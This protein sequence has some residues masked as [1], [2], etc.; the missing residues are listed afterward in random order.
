MT[1]S[2]QQET[3]SATADLQLVRSILFGQAQG[4]LADIQSLLADRERMTALVSAVVAEALQQRQDQ[5]DAVRAVL[6]P[7]IEY[8][9][10]TA[11]E[12]DPQGFSDSLYPALGPAIRKAVST[13]LAGMIRHFNE[14]LEHSLSLRALRWRWEAWRTGESFAKIALLRTLVYQVEQ[15]LLVHRETGLLLAHMECPDVIVRDPDVV[16]GMLRAVQD[17]IADSFEVTED[18]GLTSLSYGNLELLVQQGPYAVLVVAVRGNYPDGLREQ[19]GQILELIHLRHASTLRHFDGNVRHLPDFQPY[20]QDCLVQ[21]KQASLQKKPW[22]ALSIIS[23][24]LLIA[25]TGI[26][27]AAWSAWQQTQQRE[28]VVNQ[29]TQEPG[30]MITTQAQRDDEWLIAGFRDPLAR[31]LPAIVGEQATTDLDL[32]THWEPYTSMAPAL[33]ARRLQRAARVLAI[34][35]QVTAS[36]SGDVLVLAGQ[37]DQ[38][39]VA[40][41][42]E[43]PAAIAGISEIDAAAI[44]PLSADIQAYRAAES[45]IEAKAFRFPSG[46]WQIPE[47]KALRTE[48]AALVTEI[49]RLADKAA[50]IGRPFHID[51]IGLTDGAGFPVYNLELRQKRAEFMYDQLRQAGV[52]AELVQPVY[53]LGPKLQNLPA[54]RKV[55]FRVRAG[56]LAQRP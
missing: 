41:L 4:D 14:L 18:D 2:T 47:D 15:A 28:T 6:Q 20:L 7:A 27:M 52:A 31:E 39:W 56:K 49:E 24:V 12:R 1:L 34:P 36:L 11:I 43:R 13:S 46:Q 22:A 50:A 9:M 38:R 19:L 55:V 10:H 8:S 33:V 45:A 3:H 42:P 37:A 35:E 21:Q 30:Y 16:S 29:L 5:D 44:G 53:Q 51:V 54:E 32:Q 25:L 48:L 40:G 17:F 26:A 23:A